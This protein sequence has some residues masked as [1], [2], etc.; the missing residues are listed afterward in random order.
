MKAFHSFR[1]DSVNQCVWR[2]DE[3]VT[4][5][6]KAFDVL[7]YLVEHPGRLVTHEEI[8]EALWPK[9]YVNQEVVKK[10]I[11]AIRK[12]LQDEHQRPVFIETLPRRGYQF[13]AQ[14]TDEAPVASTALSEIAE[15]R[16]VGRDGALATLEGLL[17]RGQAPDRG[18]LGINA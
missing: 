18:A 15:R 2:R 1:L 4:L 13:L 10:Y 7:R 3:R 5:T 6:P 17:D 9:A 8:L 11:L 16:I 14:V 12:A